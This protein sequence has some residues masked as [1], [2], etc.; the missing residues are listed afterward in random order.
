MKT[1][2]EWAESYPILVMFNKQIELVT[3]RDFIK[4]IQLDAQKQG[5]I[6]AAEIAASIDKKNL[7]RARRRNFTF[8][9]LSS[10]SD[11]IKAFAEIMKG[12]S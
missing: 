12:N 11:S 6:D 10:T 9:S 5:M 2:E 1:P 8:A 3:Y 7:V 4:Q